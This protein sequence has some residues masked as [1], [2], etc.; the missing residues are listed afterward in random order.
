VRASTDCL[1]SV[2]IAPA[3]P[4]A[5]N[6]PPPDMDQQGPQAANPPRASESDL[7]SLKMRGSGAGVEVFGLGL[8]WSTQRVSS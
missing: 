2:M 6:R 1:D 3:G 4:S 8:G 7:T 5:L